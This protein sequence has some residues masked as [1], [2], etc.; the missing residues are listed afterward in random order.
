MCFHP[1]SYGDTIRDGMCLIIFDTL[2]TPSSRFLLSSQREDEATVIK[3][4]NDQCQPLGPDW[5]LL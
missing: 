1:P 2:L 5:Y 3:E 4:D